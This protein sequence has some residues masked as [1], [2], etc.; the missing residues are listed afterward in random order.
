MRYSQAQTTR[1]DILVDENSVEVFAEDGETVLSSL[2]FP[3]PE[4]VGL[5]FYVTPMPPGSEPARIRDLEVFPLG[6]KGRD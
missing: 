5:S 1:F 6:G 2:I 3:S 4:S